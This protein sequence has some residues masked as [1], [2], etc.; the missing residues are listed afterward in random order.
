MDGFGASHQILV[1]GATN[2]LAALDTALTRPGRFDR[3]VPLPLPDSTGRFHILSVHCRKC[4]V[5]EPRETILRVATETEGLCGAELANLVN[6]AA[7]RATRRAATCVE[8][9]DFASA[10]ADYRAS[11][12][13]PPA[14]AAEAVNGQW[15]LP[16]AA[17]LSQLSAAAAAPASASAVSAID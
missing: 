2:R 11:R 12:L 17:M 4:P 5:A 10:L 7:I 16:L 6:E 8:A 1:I 9:V 3:V 15:A 14:A 13:T